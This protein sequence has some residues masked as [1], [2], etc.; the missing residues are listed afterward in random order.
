MTGSDGRYQYMV[1]FWRDFQFSKIIVR[2]YICN[3]DPHKQLV[4]IAGSR[5]LAIQID[6]HLI[7]VLIST[8][9]MTNDID[10]NPF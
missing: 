4:Y 10:L 5:F 2:F 1:N 6:V 9:L 8:S 7:V 3:S